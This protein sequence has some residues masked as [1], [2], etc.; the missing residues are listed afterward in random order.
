MS[1]RDNY[2][3]RNL[4]LG[5]KLLA[6]GGFGLGLFLF[7]SAHLLG[8]LITSWDYS[9]D[10]LL[11]W[12]HRL[13]EIRERAPLWFWAFFAAHAASLLLLV[14]LAVRLFRLTALPRGARYALAATLRVIG[15]ADLLCWLLLPFSGAATGVLGAVMLAESAL[16]VLVVG[17]PIRDMWWYRRWKSGGRKK[18]VVVVGGGFAGLY[19]ALG[20]DRALGHHADLEI[21]VIDKKNYFLFPPLLPSVATGAIETRQVTYPFRRIFE[22]T[23]IR[24]HKQ[25]VERIDPEARRIYSRV[26]VDPGGSP[27]MPKVRIAE[28][29]YDYL[30]LAPGS[31]TQTFNTPGLVEHAFFMRELGDGVAVRNQIIDCFERA[32]REPD[33]AR[34]RELLSFVIVGAG[35]TGV[36]LAS[37]VRDLIEHVL[38]RRYPEIDRALPRVSVIQSGKQILPGWH[39]SIVKSATRQLEAHGI[40]LVFEDRV[41]RVEPFSVTLQSGRT[42]PARTCV[43][44]AGVKPAALLQSCALPKDKSGR[45]QVGPDLRVS[46]HPEVF[47]LGDAAHCLHGGKPLPPL[48]QVAFQQGSATAANLVRLLEGR[49]TRPF[50]Y[51]NFGALVSVGE[52]FAAIELL[53]VR[54]SGFVAWLI[55]RTLYLA[56]LVGFSNKLR[57]LLD[58]TLDLLVERSISQISATRQDLAAEQGEVEAIP[59][60]MPKVA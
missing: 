19:A 25:L 42:L 5:A 54:L 43:W 36:E 53:G 20:L 11:G 16:L 14:F 40:E 52:R 23:N 15:A 28:T 2:R 8:V 34:Q 55:W 32:A 7:F 48:G 38:L 13:L 24:F 49:L 4:S 26:D 59:T 57:V 22:A 45:I 21:L 17:W 50:K 9:A 27:E 31:E 12:G 29:G 46:G 10:T 35:P 30:V 6:T 44:C 3:L 37:E 1:T 33:P 47:V 60:E 18:R 41:V 56:K 58:W 51:F 39:D